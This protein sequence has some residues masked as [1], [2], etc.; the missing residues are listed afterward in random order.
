MPAARRLYRGHPLAGYPGNHGSNTD[1]YRLAH[2]RAAQH[3]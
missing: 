3:A 2:T 1:S